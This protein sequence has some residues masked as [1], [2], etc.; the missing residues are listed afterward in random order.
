MQSSSDEE[1]FHTPGSESPAPQV[2]SNSASQDD[3][4]PVFSPVPVAGR[5]RRISLGQPIH[6]PKGEL[7]TLAKPEKLMHPAVSTIKD[8][9]VTLS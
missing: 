9:K 5:T 6:P 2:E 3:T 7:V 4:S 1:S 8:G